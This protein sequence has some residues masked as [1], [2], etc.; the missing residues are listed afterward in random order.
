MCRMSA[1]YLSADSQRLQAV[2]PGYLYHCRS[3]PR[4]CGGGRS[5]GTTA[6]YEDS[7]HSHVRFTFDASL[8]TTKIE[9]SVEA[10]CEVYGEYPALIV[11]DNLANVVIDSEEQS[12][13]D[14]LMAYLHTMARAT[15]ACVVVLHHVTAAHNNADNPIPLNGV[16]GQITALPEVVLTLHQPDLEHTIGVSAVKNRGGKPDPSGRSFVSLDFDGSRMS[17]TDN[18]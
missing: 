13:Q 7:L 9:N 18:G 3:R 17:I 11:L 2:D 10:Y 6:E 12:P 16:K 4:Y 14:G 5:R 8:D 15:G 1:L